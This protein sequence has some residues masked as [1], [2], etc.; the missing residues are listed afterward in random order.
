MPRLD[1]GG[2][3]GFSEIYA[4]FQPTGRASDDKHVRFQDAKGL[5]TSQKL[6]LAK[7]SAFFGSDRLEQRAAKRAEGGQ[8]VR[9]AIMREHPQLADRI[10]ARLGE[11]HPGIDFDRGVRRG[12]LE[13]IRQAIDEVRLGDEHLASVTPTV[14]GL[15]SAPDNPGRLVGDAEGSYSQAGVE[16]VLT[17]VSDSIAIF[18]DT[19]K[20]P[21]V[22]KEG[23]PPV[24]NQFMIDIDRAQVRLGGGD[25]GETLRVDGER[26]P[27]QALRAFAGSDRACLNLSKL[28]NQ[29]ALTALL[30]GATTTFVGPDGSE[31]MPRIAGRLPDKE[32]IHSITARREGDVYR[33]DYAT[34]ARISGFTPE[35]G[36]RWSEL[37]KG[38]SDMRLA[39][40]LEISAED[41]E[42]GDFSALRMTGPPTF[43]L[44]TEV[45]A[46][47]LH[48]KALEQG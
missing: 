25:S 10:F 26:D 44:H 43:R 47:D 35:G 33:I 34:D 16:S 15:H 29:N 23:L 37:D 12:D 42:R 17:Y 7:L 40:Q 31:L 19:A 48:L 1:V 13:A 11:T 6:S 30:M 2:G 41:L 27:R 32:A 22:E 9:N 14:L 28:M 36:A 21:P 38:A 4:R 20:H 45:D 8:E 24:I 3:V 39:M 5:Y 46:T 18:N